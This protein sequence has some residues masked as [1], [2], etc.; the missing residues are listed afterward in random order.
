MAPVPSKCRRRRRFSIS[1]LFLDLFFDFDAVYISADGAVCIRGSENEGSII[2]TK[3]KSHFLEAYVE[4]GWEIESFHFIFSLISHEYLTISL[5]I[6][7]LISHDIN[8]PLRG[9]S[10]IVALFL[11]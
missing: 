4:G 5:K 1:A 2:K 11:V 10:F 7:S 3:K 9:T 6:S 8:F